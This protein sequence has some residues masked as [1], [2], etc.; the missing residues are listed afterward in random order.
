ML[1]SAQIGFSYYFLSEQLNFWFTCKLNLV[2]SMCAIKQYRRYK[3]KLR[4]RS[5]TRIAQSGRWLERKEQPLAG[6]MDTRKTSSSTSKRSKARGNDQTGKE[7]REAFVKA[8][9]DRRS[10]MVSKEKER[11]EP[12]SG[13]F[14]WTMVPHL[15]LTSRRFYF[16]D[17]SG[18]WTGGVSTSRQNMYWH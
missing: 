12:L 7:G 5:D 3:Y 1:F 10:K 16:E 9:N 13:T 15:W 6:S 8:R 17:S 2:A 11:G 14:G 4:G 18:S